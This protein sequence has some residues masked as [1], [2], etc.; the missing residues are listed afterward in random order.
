MRLASRA[1]LAEREAEARVTL[2]LA[3]F[4]SGRVRAALDEIEQAERLAT[5]ETALL[6]CAQHGILLER[7]GRLEEALARYGTAL[8]GPASRS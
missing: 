7:L 1:G 6:A 5:G 8:D 2:S 4:Q 3:L